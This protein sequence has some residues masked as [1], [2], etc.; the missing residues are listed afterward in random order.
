MEKMPSQP[1][2]TFDEIVNEA[3]RINNKHLIAI[4]DEVPMPGGNIR[5]LK[6]L[7]RN[8]RCPEAEEFTMV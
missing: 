5:E 1:L 2:V 7:L 4:E 6:N 8:T 3:C